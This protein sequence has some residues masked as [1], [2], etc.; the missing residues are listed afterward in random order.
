M[1]LLTRIILINTH[2]ATTPLQVVAAILLISITAHLCVFVISCNKIYYKINILSMQISL[3]NLHFV[4]KLLP[5]M[6]R[7]AKKHD[8]KFMRL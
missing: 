5:S 6:Q 3:P 2:F 1:I 7:E 4:R 8:L